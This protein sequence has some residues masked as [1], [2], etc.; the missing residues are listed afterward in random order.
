MPNTDNHQISFRTILRI[1]GWFW[2]A[3]FLLY[4]VLM[5]VQ[6][7]QLPN[8]AIALFNSFSNVLPLFL[9]SLLAWPIYQ[10]L[11]W[12]K[13]NRWV[14]GLLH[15]V[16]ANVFTVIWLFT[17]FWIQY[18]AVG[19]ALFTFIDVYEIAGWQYPEGLLF[20]LMINGVYS[21]LIFLSRS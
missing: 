9:L 13:G 12:R 20:Y 3:W 18:L 7:P 16:L 2:F 17:S 10:R 8:F 5:Y 1:N 19:D 4:G 6:V 21:T 11:D 14:I 15:L